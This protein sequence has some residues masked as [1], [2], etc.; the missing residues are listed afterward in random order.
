VY[1][2]G[3]NLRSRA[4]TTLLAI[5]CDL[6]FRSPR[7]HPA[8]VGKAIEI[9]NDLAVK[10]FLYSQGCDGALLFVL[11]ISYDSTRERRQNTRSIMTSAAKVKQTAAEARQY[12]QNACITNAWR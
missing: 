3:L 2:R 11:E 9:A 4:F 8:K 7:Q 6:F 10:I 1:L 5:G 12:L